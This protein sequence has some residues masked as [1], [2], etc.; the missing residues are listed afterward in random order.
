MT[1][2]RFLAAAAAWAAL[3]LAA[4]VLFRDNLYESAWS[5][6]FCHGPEAAWWCWLRNGI[7]ATNR[8]YLVGIIAGVVGL[9]AVLTAWRWAILAAI[10]LAALALQTE[11][12][13]IGALSLALCLIR[14]ARP[15]TPA[16]PS[17]APAH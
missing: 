7:H 4:A 12:A 10:P 8:F 6:A 17:R 3:C 5:H 14:A 9:L 13:D 11:S 2:W 15:W 16:A 1:G